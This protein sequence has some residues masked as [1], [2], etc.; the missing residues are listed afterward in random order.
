MPTSGASSLTF[1]RRKA[2]LASASRFAFLRNPCEIIARPDA[3][4]RTSSTS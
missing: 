3:A 1:S 2:T 4:G